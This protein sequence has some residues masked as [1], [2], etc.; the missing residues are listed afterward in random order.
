MKV[1]DVK[2]EH[3]AECTEVLVVSTIDFG[4]GIHVE[5]YC[6]KC[7]YRAVTSVYDLYRV[8]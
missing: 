2:K 4:G 7:G 6:D 8:K 3:D 1:K 5:V